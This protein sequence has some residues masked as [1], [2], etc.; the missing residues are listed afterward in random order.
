MVSREQWSSILMQVK[1]D[2]F[3]V[4][5]N[6]GV[7][8]LA[9]PD[10]RVGTGPQTHFSLNSFYPKAS[11]FPILWIP[12]VKTKYFQRVDFYCI[13]RKWFKYLIFNYFMM[14]YEWVE[15][16]SKIFQIAFQNYL[17]CQTFSFIKRQNNRYL[18]MSSFMQFNDCIWLRIC[19]KTV[20]K[21]WMWI[22]SIC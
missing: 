9:F 18:E 3:M 11:I 22:A 17:L 1:V 15:R 8:S 4:L 10:G 20:Q 2:Y 13:M 16:F 5:Y 6:K 14:Y 21:M 19:L 12:A 7:G